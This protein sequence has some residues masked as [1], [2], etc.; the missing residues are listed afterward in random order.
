MKKLKNYCILIICSFDTCF[1]FKIFRSNNTKLVKTALISL[2]PLFD[3]TTFNGLIKPSDV[4]T[5]KLIMKRT[6]DIIRSLI[7]TIQ[8]YNYNPQKYYH[9]FETDELFDEYICQNQHEIFKFEKYLAFYNRI[10]R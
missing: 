1:A 7:K 4:L 5:L 2:L 10:L 9:D 3:E 6:E 8:T